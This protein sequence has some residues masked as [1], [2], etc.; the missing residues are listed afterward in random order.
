MEKRNHKFFL[1]FLPVF[2]LPL[3]IVYFGCES[4]T[5]ESVVWGAIVSS[6]VM[7]GGILSLRFTLNRSINIFLGTLIGGI[8]LRLL[9]I[10]LSGFYIRY[11]SD[12]NVKD[13][14]I[15]LLGYYFTLQFFEVMYFNRGIKKYK[16]D[17]NR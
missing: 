14:F 8:L 12:L 5:F 3:F 11:F 4:K 16:R 15:S 17:V 7:T 2:I 1:Y 6:I 9:I 13:Y 10:L